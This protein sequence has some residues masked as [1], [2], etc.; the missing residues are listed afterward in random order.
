MDT[1]GIEP[2]AFRRNAM[3]DSA[4]RAR[5]HCAKCPILSRKK[6]QSSIILKV[7]VYKQQSASLWR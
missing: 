3:N 1:V 6:Q 5:Y 4:K 2:T 7:R